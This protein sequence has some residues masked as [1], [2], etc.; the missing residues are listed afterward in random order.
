[1][2]PVGKQRTE[3]KHGPDVP[4]GSVNDRGGWG[5][6]AKDLTLSHLQRGPERLH[7]SRR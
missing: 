2:W 4:I 3:S 5:F 6:R 1:V 7:P